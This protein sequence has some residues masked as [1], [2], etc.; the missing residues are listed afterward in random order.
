M[1]HINVA[2][3]VRP[4]LDHDPEGPVWI[5]QEPNHIILDKVPS[6]KYNL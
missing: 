1:E 3:R 6:R 2:V 4:F 5:I